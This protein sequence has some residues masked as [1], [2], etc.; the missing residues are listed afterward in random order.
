MTTELNI[1]GIS[2]HIATIT[3]NRDPAN[4]W[5][6]AAL[7]DFEKKLDRIENDRNVRVVILTGAGEKCF[8]AGFDIKDAADS[9]RTAVKGQ[10]L[11]RRID[12]FEK[13]FIAAINGHAFGGGF[14]LALCCHFR[15]MADSPKAGVGLTELNLGIIPGWG[16]TQRLMREVGRT[17]ALDMILF[18]KR[19]SAAESLDAGLVHQIVPPEKLMDEAFSFAQKIAE[20]PPVAVGWVLRAMTAGIYEGMEQG[21]EAEREGLAATGS[22]KDAAEGFT[23]FLEKRRPVFNGE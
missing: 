4:A 20:R 18:S 6:L 22:S 15:L 14:E 5:S 17:K 11:W 12:R 16:G 8:S 9:A 13:P 2:N 7:E 23:A 21:L 10:N 1:L 19:L 3:F